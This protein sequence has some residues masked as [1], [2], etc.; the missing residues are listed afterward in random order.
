MKFKVKII[1]T[2]VLG[3]IVDARNAE[4]AAQKVSDL[5]NDGTIYLD[6]DDFLDRQIKV[7]RKA[8][9]RDIRLYD[10]Y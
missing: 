7:E 2:S 10:K 1:E 8:T 6:Y 5:T 9:P 3:V 4:E